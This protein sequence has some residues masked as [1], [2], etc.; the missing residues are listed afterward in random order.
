MKKLAKRIWSEARPITS[1]DEV[2]RYLR[3]RGLQLTAY[4][5]TLR[6]HP[7]LGYY[8]KDTNEK[9]RKVRDYPAMLACFQG[10]DGHA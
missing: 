10:P 2:D 8:E 4:P 1:G 3:N 7:A 6:F 5:A 9:S